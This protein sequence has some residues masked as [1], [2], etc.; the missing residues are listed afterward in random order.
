MVS[1]ILE[2]LGKP[3]MKEYYKRLIVSLLTVSLGWATVVCCCIAPSVASLFHKTVACSHC[4]QQDAQGTPSNPGACQQ[5]LTSA[6]IL[7]NQIVFSPVLSGRHVVLSA[8]LIYQRVSLTSSLLTAFPP[9]GPP[10][11]NL[12]PLYLRSFILRV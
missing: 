10:P 7:H 4:H 3:L 8:S 2:A 9:G 1:F 12:A 5:Q 6:D 11:G